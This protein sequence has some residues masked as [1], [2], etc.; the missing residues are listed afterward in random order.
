MLHFLFSAL[1][2]QPLLESLDLLSPSLL[3]SA[4]VLFT[5]DL[6]TSCRTCPS[7]I[8]SGHI[9]FFPIP[10]IPPP[11]PPSF[12][13]ALLYLNLPEIILK[14]MYYE[15]ILNVSGVKLIDA[16]ANSHHL[17]YISHI[18]DGGRWRRRLSGN[19]KWSRGKLIKECCPSA[20]PPPQA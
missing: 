19:V 16:H 5:T 3:F 18:L 15:K 6:S 17:L 8:P 11:P 2:S 14:T 12:P 9:L 7:V 4:S 20:E 1:A 10:S 13:A